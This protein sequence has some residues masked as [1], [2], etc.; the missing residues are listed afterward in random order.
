[1]AKILGDRVHSRGVDG[2]AEGSGTV[3]LAPVRIEASPPDSFDVDRE[4][5]IAGVMR[6]IAQIGSKETKAIAKF[7]AGLKDGE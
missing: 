1:M 3:A 4:P 6:S 7:V 2:L 5:L